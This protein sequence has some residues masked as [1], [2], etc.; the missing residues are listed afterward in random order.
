[1]LSF[2]RIRTLKNSAIVAGHAIFV[3]EDMVTDTTKKIKQGKAG[4]PSGV[5]VEMIQSGENRLLLQYQD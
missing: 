3:T 5:I 1:M 2:H 4:G